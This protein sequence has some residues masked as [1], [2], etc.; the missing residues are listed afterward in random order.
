MLEEAETLMMC[1]ETKPGSMGNVRLDLSREMRLRNNKTYYEYL[2][3]TFEKIENYTK[4]SPE[5]DLQA[6][7][8]TIDAVGKEHFQWIK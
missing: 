7:Y 4:R 5:R 8:I 6:R 2:N 1:E 3:S